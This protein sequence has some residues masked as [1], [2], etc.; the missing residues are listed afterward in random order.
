MKIKT[1]L[2]I[3]TKIYVPKQAGTN[4]PDHQTMS[5]KKFEMFGKR[6]GEPDHLVWCSNNICCKFFP[7]LCLIQ[8]FPDHSFFSQNFVHR[9]FFSIN[10]KVSHFLYFPKLYSEE[11]IIHLVLLEYIG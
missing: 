2:E 3:N 11:N 6:I 8:L 1:I 7:D 10:L 4:T 5:G 9:E